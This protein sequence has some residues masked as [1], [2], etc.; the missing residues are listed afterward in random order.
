M[1][2]SFKFAG[3]AVLCL[4]CLKV[5]TAQDLSPRAY[6]ITPLHSNAITLTWSF[7]DGSIDYNGVLPV[8]G[9]TGTY[10]VPI[11]SY[12]HGFGLFGRSANIVASL[13]YG[14]GNF[15]GTTLGAERHLYRSGL[16]DSAYRFSV[17]L[18]GGPAM[19]PDEFV[20]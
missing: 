9:A 7:Y 8:N 12:Y 13:P 20:K 17:N 18:K 2:H 4:A 19:P 3:L 10:S 1:R 15:Q 14:V 11:F 16:L 6:V 5:A